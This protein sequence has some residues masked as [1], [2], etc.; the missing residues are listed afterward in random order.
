MPSRFTVLPSTRIAIGLAILIGLLPGCS[1]SPAAPTPPPPPVNFPAPSLT[2][3]VD[4]AVDG[5]V[6]SEIAVNFPAPA[7]T[8]G[9]P[10]V[11]VACTPSS[12]GAFPLGA[13]NV[14]CTAR[15]NINRQTFCEFTVTVTPAPLPWETF[16]AFGDSVTSGETGSA[17]FHPFFT[18][19]ANAYPTQLQAMLRNRYPAQMR[20][21]VINEGLG[22]ERATVS[23]SRLPSVLARHRPQVLLMLT[24]FN[25]LLHDGI[26]GADGIA[27]S[28]RDNV[29][30]AFGAGVSRVFVSTLPPSG[31]GKRQ[32]DAEAILMTNALIRQFVA[33]EGAVIVDT[34]PAFLGRESE[35]LES[36]GLHLRPEG[37]RVLA[38]KFFDAIVTTVR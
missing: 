16:L 18:D 32:L 15:D 22:G 23:V 34:Y 28:L 3:P 10:P 36:D 24:G 1:S 31:P 30:A 27:D 38:Q 11:S 7:L 26:D 21:E 20:L 19:T 9:T 17:A 33:A 13:T 5:V 37:N 12:G 14:V 6:G 29:R 8:G 35:L 2:C 4:S 25:D